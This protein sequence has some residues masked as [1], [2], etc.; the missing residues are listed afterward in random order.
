MPVKKACN[1]VISSMRKLLDAADGKL[2][3]GAELSKIQQAVYQLLS[4][5]NMRKM[6]DAVDAPTKRK[7]T[8]VEEDDRDAFIDV[9]C[10]VA[11]ADQTKAV[12]QT[13]EL[14]KTEDAALRWCFMIQ[15]ITLNKDGTVTPS[16]AMTP[17]DSRSMHSSSQDNS[18]E[19]AMKIDDVVEAM[20]HMSA[21]DRGYRSHK[22][23]TDQTKQQVS[24]AKASSVRKQLSEVAA[25]VSERLSRIA[26]RENRKK[27]EF[28][29]GYS[30]N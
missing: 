12:Y 1:S 13:R 19:V 20:G 6:F 26:A 4:S 2:D 14:G 7:K 22:Q 8:K 3:C 11:E 23:Q 16:R 15:R 17:P 10:K 18:P 21:F 25:G 9:C 29:M 27:T 24:K 30:S 5:S 28:R